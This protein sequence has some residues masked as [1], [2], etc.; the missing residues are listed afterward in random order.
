MAGAYRDGA[1]LDVRRELRALGP[2][3]RESP[4]VKEAQAVCDEWARR[5]RVNLD[6]LVE[7]LDAHPTPCTRTTSAAAVRGP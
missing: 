3:V 7:R 1:H 4:H 5:V 2:D 6:R